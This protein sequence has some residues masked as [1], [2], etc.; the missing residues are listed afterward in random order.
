M[1][2]DI[3]A[4]TEEYSFAVGSPAVGNLAADIPAVDTLL[5]DNLLSQDQSSLTNPKVQHEDEGVGKKP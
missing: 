4:H 3:A 1:V 5:V 2:E